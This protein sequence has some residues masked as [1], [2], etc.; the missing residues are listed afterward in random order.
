VRTLLFL[1]SLTL[2]LLVIVPLTALVL[3]A[4][5]ADVV[6]AATD[7]EVV[8]AIAM[9]L[10]CAALAVL[11]GTI[12]GVPLGY[13]LAH[14]RS[15]G[16]RALGALFDLPLVVP[17]PILGVALLLVFGRE[18]LLGA[19]L[20]EGFGVSVVSS[21][22]GIVIAMLLVSAPFI[23]KGAR[24]GFLAVPSEMERAA[25]SLGASELLCLWRV[26]LPLASRNIRSGAVLAWARAISEF[27]SI[28]VLAYYPMTAPVLIWDRFSASGLRA[29]LA[30]ATVLLLVCFLVFALLQAFGPAATER[31]RQER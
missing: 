30:P 10:G 25:R 14:R 28:V 12:L 7:R 23:V 4:P 19:A 17:H 6:A 9:S 24:D 2:A 22:A 18:R 15:F 13:L 11:L 20:R 3:G 5:L 26:S 8:V 21:G 16:I 1:P 29:A 27:G 31:R